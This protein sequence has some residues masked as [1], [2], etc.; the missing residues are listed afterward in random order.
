[1]RRCTPSTN[2]KPPCLA[3]AFRRPH[4]LSLAV[5]GTWR[6]RRCPEQN[7]CSIAHIR[8]N[9]RSSCPSSAP[10]RPRRWAASA[11]DR[12]CTRGDRSVRG[13]S[14]GLL[15]ALGADPYVQVCAAELATLEVAAATE[16]PAALLGLSRAEL[17]VARLVATGLI[18]REVAAEL[19]VSVKTVE[20]HLRNIFIKLDITSRRELGARSPDHRPRRALFWTPQG[21]ASPPRQK[22]RV[23]P[24]VH[25]W[26][27]SSSSG[28]S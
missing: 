6:W 1:M 10:G 5:E 26:G 21:T 28:V 18:N 13:G 3:G 15:L 9:R 2:S 17:A 7:R 8:L 23:K 11:L 19:Y 22:P 27:Q 24:G 20:Y 4:W 25:P 12:R 16:G 14:S